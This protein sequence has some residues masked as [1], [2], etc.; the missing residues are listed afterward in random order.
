MRVNLFF[1][2][3]QFGGGTTAFT[4]HLYRALQLAGHDPVILRPKER[5]EERRRTFASY[6]GVEYRNVSVAEALA[7]AAESPSLLTAPCNSKYLEF[8]PDVIEKLIRVG[9][10]VVVHDP[11]ELEI[12]DHHEHVKHGKRPI[13]IRPTMKQFYPNALEIPHPYVR[14]FASNVVPLYATRPWHAMSVARVTFVK[15]T[16]IILA[17]N[18]LLRADGK[19]EVVL[20]GAE[21]RL[22]T[23]HKLSKLFP[24]YQQGHTGFP[25]VWHASAEEC[26]KSLYAVDMTWFPHDGGGSQY[27]FM[28]AWDAGAVNII[29]EDW[30]RYKDTWPAEMV[31]G[32]NCL[33]VDGPQQLFNI[34]TTHGHP[35]LAPWEEYEEMI[36]AGFAALQ[37][38]DPVAVAEAYVEELIT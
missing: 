33:A 20:R 5:S 12:Y 27:S 10:R 26:A 11:N 24:E 19:Q 29:H 14:R 21:N 7:A 1:M 6:E 28:E 30:L 23:R 9:M 3:R 35:V 18:R 2:Y 32:T 36:E 25:M 13:C 8:D 16:E 22:Y 31:H 4:A 34:L 37:R 17:A 38:H 15:R